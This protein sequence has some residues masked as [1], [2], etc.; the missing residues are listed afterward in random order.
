MKFAKTSLPGV[1]M[2]ELELREDE[3]GFLARTYCEKEFVDHGLNVRWPQCNLTLTKRRGMIRGMH[4]QAVF[5]TIAHKTRIFGIAGSS[6]PEIYSF[7][8]RIKRSISSS[9]KRKIIDPLNFDVVFVNQLPQAI[10]RMPGGR[11][12]LGVVVRRTMG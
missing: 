12:K 10:Q 6:C 3:R 9:Q 4:F 2:I 11:A 8:M 1:W 5:Q 7:P